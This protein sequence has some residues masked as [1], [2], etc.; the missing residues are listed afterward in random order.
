MRAG[1]AALMMQSTTWPTGFADSSQYC[2][3]SS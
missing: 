1:V 2:L 3:S